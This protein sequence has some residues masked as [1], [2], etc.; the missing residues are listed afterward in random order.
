[1]ALEVEHEH[2]I[3]QAGELSVGPVR[4]AVF[5][6]LA[7]DHGPYAVLRVSL[8]GADQAHELTLRPGQQD[9]I[10]QIGRLTLLAAAPSTR[11]Q[12]GDVRIGIVRPAGGEQSSDA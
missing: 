12:R 2:A 8:A 6:T 7:D 11:Q 10:A 4:I 9:E 3:E 5:R 1:M